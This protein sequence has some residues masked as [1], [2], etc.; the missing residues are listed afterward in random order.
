MPLNES[1]VR[2]NPV[3]GPT[4]LRLRGRAG[5]HTSWHTAWAAIGPRAASHIAVAYLPTKNVHTRER[6]LRPG[7]DPGGGE[8][9]RGDDGR[10]EYG[11]LT[12]G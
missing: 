8:L 5:A 4:R 1:G 9:V 7:V 12:G 11:E 3:S 10:G 6:K 2:L